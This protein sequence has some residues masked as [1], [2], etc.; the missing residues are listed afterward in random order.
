MT[1]V[2]VQDHILTASANNF[3]MQWHD[4]LK[5]SLSPDSFRGNYLCVLS[6]SS[7]AGGESIRPFQGH[8]HATL[9]RGVR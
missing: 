2:I 6:V 8:Y 9:F 1:L 5:E 3:A 7:A 4:V